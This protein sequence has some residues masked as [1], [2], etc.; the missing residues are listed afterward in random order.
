V[1]LGVR[2]VLLKLQLESWLEVIPLTEMDLS[3]LFNELIAFEK[4]SPLQT[5]RVNHDS[6]T[7]LHSLTPFAP[8]D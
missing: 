6:Q 3:Q 5:V 1:K 2:Q 4:T 8:V 7:F